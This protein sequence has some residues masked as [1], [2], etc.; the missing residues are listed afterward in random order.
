KR[1]F[2]FMNAVG[3]HQDVMT[4]LHESGHACHSFEASNLPYFQQRQ[5][6]LEFAEV[7]SMGMELLASSYLLKDQGGFY[8]ADDFHRARKK[9]LEDIIL[10]LPYMAVVDGFQHW[11]YENPNQAMEPDNCDRYWAKLWNQFMVGYDWQGL[12]DVMATGWQ[13]K[14]H[15]YLEPF[16]YVE[17]G[18]AQLG[19]CQIWANA[20][21]DQATAVANYLSALALGG[22]KSLP[23]LY[24]QAGAKFR[25]DTNVL[26]MIVDLLE[27]KIEAV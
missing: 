15:I 10:F 24:Q 5:V 12:E 27:Q 20:L 2:I 22:T 9:H 25:F 8:E 23:E 19:A 21:Q 7:A 18:L 17:Y 1:P 26:Q 4:L 3:L 13:R 14:L 11:V 6:G 16:Y